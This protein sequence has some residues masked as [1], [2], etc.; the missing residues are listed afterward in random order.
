MLLLTIIFLKITFFD[1][2]NTVHIFLSLTPFLPRVSV[3]H[4]C[5][6]L[7][8]EPL[9]IL[10]DNPHICSSHGTSFYFLFFLPSNSSAWKCIYY[11][12]HSSNNLSKCL[13]LHLPAPLS[14]GTLDFC[15]FFSIQLP[16]Q[17]AHPLLLTYKSCAYLSL[18]L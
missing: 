17:G 13:C 8:Q 2:C 5:A 14:V 1:F 7:E 10:V 3:W 4:L 18:S 15:L 9:V 16:F 11:L 12:S 6:L